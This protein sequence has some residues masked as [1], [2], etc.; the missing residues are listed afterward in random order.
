[1]DIKKLTDCCMEISQNRLN[2]INN[3]D[4]IEM[5]GEDD[6][7]FDSPITSKILDDDNKETI[8]I[9]TNFFKEEYLELLRFVTPFFSNRRCKTSSL[10][11]TDGFLIL[12]FYFKYYENIA[13][14]SVHF[15]IP[16]SII[17][18]KIKKL[19]LLLKEPLVNNFIKEIS[20]RQQKRENMLLEDY[21]E[22]IGII[23]CTVQIINKPKLSYKDSK[24]YYS[25]KHQCYCLKKE[26]LHSLNGICTSVSS[27]ELGAT[28]DYTIFKQNIQKFKNYVKKSQD[29]LALEDNGELNEV[30]PFEWALMMDKGYLGS[31]KIIRSI[32]PSKKQQNKELD[33]DTK[34]RNNKIAKNRIIIENYYGRLKTL[35]NITSRPY[36]CNHDTY[37]D[38]FDICVALTNYNIINNP[39]RDNDGEIYKKILALYNKQDEDIKKRQREHQIKYRDNLKVKIGL[40]S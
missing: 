30:F 21:P 40:D 15:K 10:S 32:H 4:I 24:K 12:L 29:E 7:L 17:N 19:I 18:A 35:W 22:V 23:D 3:V 33:R 34:I 16:S 31:N 2:I 20:Y 26:T 8:K 13:F 9:L 27:Y 6:L 11:D 25:K 36:K 39:L 37:D 14:L 38:Y 28:H 5:E 1:M